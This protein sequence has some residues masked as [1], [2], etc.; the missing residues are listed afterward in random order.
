MA[1]S[2]GSAVSRQVTV[3]P[4]LVRVIRPAPDSTSRCFMTAGSDIEIGLASSLTERG[5]CSSNR[6]SR[7]RRVGSARAA[8]VR[9]RGSCIY[10]TIWLS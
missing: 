5:W 3:R 7:A 9:S 1:C 8:K 2:M 4:V 6:A 10:L